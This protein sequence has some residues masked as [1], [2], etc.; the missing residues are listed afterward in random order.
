MKRFF[1]AILI[2]CT[3]FATAMAQDDRE[4]SEH[5][6]S[7][8]N[9]TAVRREL[10]V[11]WRSYRDERYGNALS[12]LQEV[13]EMPEMGD[14]PGLRSSLPF[15]VGCLHSLL[16]EP[17]QAID[18]LHE[19]IAA[20]FTSYQ[21]YGDE[22]D[23][24]PIRLEPRFRLLMAE[25]RKRNRISPL[26]WDRRSFSTVAAY[27]EVSDLPNMSRVLPEMH[28]DDLQSKGDTEYSKLLRVAQWVS[29]QWKSC[30]DGIAGTKPLPEL[31]A[32]CGE[33]ASVVASAAQASGM[34]A[35][36]VRLMPQDVERR[37]DSHA[38]AEVWLSSL[39]KWVVA[40][41]Q[42]GVVP[43]LRGVPL[44]AIEVQAALSSG[45]ELT[46][47][48]DALTCVRWSDSVL[49]YLYYF[50]YGRGPGA[51]DG[52]SQLILKAV[53]AP[54]PHSR[55]GNKAAFE[56]A[57]FFSNPDPLYAGTPQ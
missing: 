8:A 10:A 16:H 44:N 11:A 48:T 12:V 50:A 37:A 4:I 52:H 43:Q 13:R 3:L 32:S 40:D 57:L 45:Q 18:S 38:I 54:E 9:Q 55:N 51:Q 47:G 42:F 22:P 26:L 25:I 28:L 41:G 30:D 53:G 29:A 23:L 2:A 1:W 34:R 14:V 6:W 20:G 15:G 46:C 33:H 56:Q 7:Q 27:S 35:R 19:A 21:S 17:S 5:A 31:G 36:V 24:D 39:Q 49:Q